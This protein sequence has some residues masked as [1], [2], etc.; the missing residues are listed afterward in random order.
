MPDEPQTK[1]IHTLPIQPSLT[2]AKNYQL[3]DSQNSATF[4]KLPAKF[5]P[6][7]LIVKCPGIGHHN[8]MLIIGIKKK[9]DNKIKCKQPKQKQKRK[10]KM[11]PVTNRAFKYKC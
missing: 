3:K 9:L 5:P 1:N 7:L 6:P 4:I 2:E 11:N 8:K 10:C